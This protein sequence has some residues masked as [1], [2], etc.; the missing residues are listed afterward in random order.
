MRPDSEI[1]A[2]VKALKDKGND[3]FKQQKFLDAQENYQEAL[4]EALKIKEK[5]QEVRDFVKTLHLNLSVVANKPPFQNSAVI[6]HTTCALEF[7]PKNTK[8]LFLRG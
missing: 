7:D 4:T 2:D 1:F 8:A 5:T 6:D 3:Y